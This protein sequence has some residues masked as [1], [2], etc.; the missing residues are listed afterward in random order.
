VNDNRRESRGQRRISLATGVYL[1]LGL[2]GIVGAVVLP[3]LIA[4][5]D[6]MHPRNITRQLAAWESQYD[7]VSTLEEAKSRIALME[8]VRDHYRY[9]DM[10]E[11]RGNKVIA[12]LAAQRAKTLKAMADSLR[13]YSGEDHGDDPTGWQKWLDAKPTNRSVQ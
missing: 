11:Y 5:L 9:E 3:R 4:W 2:I 13:A 10:L 1:S 7:E 12:A 6:E 8:Y